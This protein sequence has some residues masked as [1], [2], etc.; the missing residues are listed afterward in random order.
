[1]HGAEQPSAFDQ[2]RISIVSDQVLGPAKTLSF[3]SYLIIRIALRAS[4]LF[5]IRVVQRVRQSTRFQGFHFY[6]SNI[7][8][9]NIPGANSIIRKQRTDVFI[10]FFLSM[11]KKFS[12]NISC[13]CILFSN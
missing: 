9:A 8:G 4:F 5:S 7:P 2:Q 11:L 12:Y 10:G 13:V 6:V 3:A 1:M